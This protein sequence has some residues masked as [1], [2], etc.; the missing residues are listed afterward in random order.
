MG[1]DECG[2]EIPVEVTDEVFVDECGNDLEVYYKETSYLDECGLGEIVRIWT[3]EPLCDGE[4]MS[5]EQDI[6][7]KAIGHCYG[8]PRLQVHCAHRL[9][10]TGRLAQSGPPR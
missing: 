1:Y 9:K 3:A 5:V 2:A 10:P 7:V 8:P 4:V 6:Y